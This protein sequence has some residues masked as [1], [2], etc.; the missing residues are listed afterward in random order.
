MRID[1]IRHG[2][3]RA[4]EERLYCGHTDLPLSMR[5][6]AEIIELRNRG[7]YQ[8]SQAY[9][10]STPLRAIQTLKLIYG[11]VDFE[12]LSELMEYNFGRFE[13]ESYN[14]LEVNGDYQKWINDTTGEATCPG[15]ESRNEF[16]DRTI[17]GFHCILRRLETKNKQSACVICHGGTI[18]YIMEYLIPGQKDYFEWQPSCGRGYSLFIEQKRL[19]NYKKI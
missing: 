16:Y 18:A 2:K 17:R 9:F 5:G 8:E 14:N 1:L 11:N 6:E 12:S 10:A 15:G 19:L 4:N 7:T 13:M 3:T